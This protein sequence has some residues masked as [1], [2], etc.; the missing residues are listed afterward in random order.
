[1][2]HDVLDLAPVV[3]ADDLAPAVDRGTT[4]LG[5]DPEQLARVAHAEDLASVGWRRHVV[6]LVEAFHRVGERGGEQSTRLE[7]LP[8]AA[9]ERR[10]A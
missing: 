2:N 8:R 1:M 7:V 10:A 4:L 9:Q 3:R 5:H 6:V